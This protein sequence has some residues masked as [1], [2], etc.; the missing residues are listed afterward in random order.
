MSVYNVSLFPSDDPLIIR[1]GTHQVIKCEVNG[2]ATPTPTKTWYLG[3]TDITNTA[4]NNTSFINI[5]GRRENNKKTIQCRATNINEEP[6]NASTTLMVEC[7]NRQL[8][9]KYVETLH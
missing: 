7:K 9:I 4:G 5:T 2:N 3:S 8:Q 6:K 1:E